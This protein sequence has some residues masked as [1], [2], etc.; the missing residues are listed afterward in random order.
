MTPTTA[1]MLRG[2][3]SLS[4]ALVLLLLSLL[5]QLKT[6]AAQEWKS[7]PSPPQKPSCIATNAD[8]DT[9]DATHPCYGSGLFIT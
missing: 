2:V 5:A 7:P 6:G 9:C 4:L 8:T 1:T 3:L